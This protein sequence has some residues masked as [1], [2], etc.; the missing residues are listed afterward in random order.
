MLTCSSQ[1]RGQQASASCSFCLGELVLVVWFWTP[2]DKLSFQGFQPPDRQHDHHFND[3]S[4]KHVRSSQFSLSDQTVGL[5]SAPCLWPLIG[6]SW[7]LDVPASCKRA[8]GAEPD[9]GNACWQSFLRY[10][11]WPQAF[12]H[13]RS[14]GG[15]RLPNLAQGGGGAPGLAAHRTTA[16]PL[17]WCGMLRSDRSFAVR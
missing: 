17:T 4:L 5:Q 7:R 8:V 12:G 10:I 15:Q 3:T 13:R 6:H 2:V 9:F 1:Q 11:H 14:T 16:S